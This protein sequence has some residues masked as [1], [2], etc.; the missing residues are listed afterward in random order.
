ME[1]VRIV[2]L[3][4]HFIGL[5]AIIG[6]FLAQLRRTEPSFGVMLAGAITQLVSGAVLVGMSY[7]LSNPVDNAKIAVKLV[8]ALLV[9]L[10]V[11]GALIARRRGATKA[12]KP[13]FHTAG[14]LAIINV[15]VAVAWM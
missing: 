10:A 6:G 4:I 8:I 1:I 15:I 13:F 12:V 14:G 11:I 2:F 9:L 3:I 7:A 5:A